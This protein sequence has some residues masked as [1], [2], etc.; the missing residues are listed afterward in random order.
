MM[1]TFTYTNNASS[2]DPSGLGAKKQSPFQMDSLSVQHIAALSG[3]SPTAYFVWRQVMEN[4]NN[5]LK[6]SMDSDEESVS[7]E[8]NA[9]TLSKSYNEIHLST[10]QSFEENELNTLIESSPMAEINKQDHN[11]NTPLLWAISEGRDDI[12]SLLVE[13]G[14][15]INSQNFEG[16]TALF[17]AAARG[18]TKMV[19]FL[20]TNG[21]HPHITNLD[22][23]LAVHIAASN[24]H[25]SVLR[26]FER[27]YK[28]GSSPAA[29]FSVQDD[30]GD[31]P[32]H[33]AVRESQIECVRF[34]VEQ[35]RVDVD[36]RNE[37][38]ESPIELASCFGETAIVSFLLP[39]SQKHPHLGSFEE[40]AMDEEDDMT[41]DIHQEGNWKAFREQQ[42]VNHNN[43]G[44]MMK[45]HPAASH[46]TTS[47]I[48]QW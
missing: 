1:N 13:Q 48:S 15:D 14:A 34:L 41:T 38:L 21:A 11:G 16:E 6:S 19:E 44:M 27:L 8:V 33:H 3:A 9:I 31:S 28:S 4:A 39:Y 18:N 17:L 2:M 24:G 36:M 40:D 37:D 5:A 46:L 32:L 22:G 12:A 7:S 45:V 26:V 25:V 30:N 10:F 43:N 20:L 42:I 35:C 29:C 23:A 47:P